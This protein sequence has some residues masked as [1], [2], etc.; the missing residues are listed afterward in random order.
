MKRSPI[1]RFQYRVF[2]LE[3]STWGTFTLL[4]YIIYCTTHNLLWDYVCECTRAVW[5][6]RVGWTMKYIW[7]MFVRAMPVYRTR[8]NLYARWND[9]PK[10]WVYGRTMIFK[11]KFWRQFSML[12]AMFKKSTNSVPL[13]FR[14]GYFVFSTLDRSDVQ[15]SNLFYN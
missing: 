4:L 3:N 7:F 10:I 8:V 15:I 14:R 2:T 5:W 9:Q 13:S 12:D 11:L 1:V 6:V